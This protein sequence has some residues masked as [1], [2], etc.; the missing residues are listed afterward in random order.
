MAGISRETEPDPHI[1]I[2]AWRLLRQTDYGRSGSLG[3]LAHGGP[4]LRRD[5]WCQ[6]PGSRTELGGP[7]SPM[8]TIASFSMWVVVRLRGDPVQLPP[9][10]GPQRRYWFDAPSSSGVLDH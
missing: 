6:V 8:S 5:C 10:M 9:R 4:T 1:V 2:L 3:G 7:P